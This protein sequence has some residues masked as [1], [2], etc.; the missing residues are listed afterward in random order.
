ACDVVVFFMV[1]LSFRFD[2]PEPT[3]QGKQRHP[4]GKLQHQPG[5]PQEGT[6][7]DLDQVLAGYQAGY[8]VYTCG[9]DRYMQGVLEA[10]ER[11]GFPEEAR[12]LEYFSVPEVPEY[13]NH[14]FTLR[15]RK[16]GRDL[17]VPA[18]K[19]ATDVLAEAGIGVD[20]KCADGICGV[21]KCDLLSGEVEHRDFVLSKAQ[22]K[23]AVILCQSRAAQKDGTIEVDL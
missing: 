17:H 20:V 4:S 8:H 2:H 1:L 3:A 13:E 15:L 21:C 7:A 5:H 6:R 12:H 11:Q 23:G 10:A 18:D 14:P 16:S 9:P 22:R 19:S